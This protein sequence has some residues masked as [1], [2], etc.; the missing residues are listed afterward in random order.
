MQ[1]TIRPPP[2][3]TELREEVYQYF[4]KLFG[5]TRTQALASALSQPGNFFFLRTNSLRTH[6][7]QLIQQLQ[8]ENIAATILYPKLGTVAIPIRKTGPVPLHDKLVVADKASSEN[9]LLGSHLYRPGVKRLDRFSKGDLITVISPKGHIVG[10]GIACDDSSRIAHR[11]HGQVVKILDSYY[12]VPSISDLAAYKD[13]FFYSQSLP[14]MLVA[15]I[16]DPQQGETIIDFC[17][18]PGGKSTHVA[19]LVKNQCRL[20]AVDRSERRINHLLSEAN[21]LG[22]SCLAP[23]VGRAKEFVAQNPTLKADRVL[24]DPPC[25]ALGVRPQLY[26]ETTL[27]QI[28]STASYQRMILD[29]AVSALRPGGYLVYSTCTLTIEENEHNIQYLTDTYSLTLEPQTPFL[30][31]KGL[32]GDS[33]VKNGVQRFYPDQHGFP[34]YFIAKL[35]K[36]ETKV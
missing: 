28:Q 12:N 36:P 18:A 23:F 22:I 15:P 31:S 8:D 24:V 3:S 4:V 14:A 20:I 5:A 19:Q 10:S 27:I 33:A 2:E 35:R 9:V 16:L 7:Q 1:D 17:A 25:T 30:G 29:S 13:G 26:A 6:D 21:R 32:A 11:K 34:G